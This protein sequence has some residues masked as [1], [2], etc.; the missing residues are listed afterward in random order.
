MHVINPY[1]EKELLSRL[2][3]GDRVAFDLIYHR[4]SLKIYGNILRMVK[5]ADDAQELL[6][7]VF[8]KAL[9]K[10]ITL[11]PFYFST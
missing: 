2:K 5:D 9:V 7:N 3:E 10:H 1:D 6:Q 4:Y 8:P 11:Y